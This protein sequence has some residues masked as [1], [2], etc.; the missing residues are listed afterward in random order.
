MLAFESSAKY[1]V[2][3][4]TLSRQRTINNFRACEKERKKKTKKKH[5]EPWGE[6]L[7]EN[8]NVASLTCNVDQLQ[9]VL[10][11]CMNLN[12]ISYIALSLMIPIAA[13]KRDMIY[14]IDEDS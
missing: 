4:S 9:C 11:L 5:A 10:V 3:F 7:S 14:S 8:F 2:V 1:Q 12:V 6:S 13:D